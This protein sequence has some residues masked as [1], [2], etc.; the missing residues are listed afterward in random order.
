MIVA[1]DIYIYIFLYVNM[2]KYNN[3]VFLHKN[4]EA[5]VVSG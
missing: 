4:K 1:Q 3:T 2:Y 5:N